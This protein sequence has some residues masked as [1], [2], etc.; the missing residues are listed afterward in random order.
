MQH[1]MSSSLADTSDVQDVLAMTLGVAQTYALGVAAETGIADRLKDGPRSV[2]EIAKA[3]TLEQGALLRLMRVLTRLGLLEEL[4]PGTFVNTGK[5]RLLQTGAPRSVRH[6]AMLMAQECFA[7]SWPHL[8]H[9]V[10]TGES[11]F[12]KVSGHR[13]Y[14]YFRR[15][16]AVGSVMNQAM[17][18]LS[19]QEGIVIRDAYEFSS[20]LLIVDVGG[21]RGGLLLSILEAHASI[22][23]I[24]LELPHVAVEA[25][26]VLATQDRLRVVVGDCLREVPAGGDLYILKRVLPDHTDDMALTAL[27]NV[28]SAIAPQGR[29]IIADPDA[30][31]L[32]GRGFDMLMLMVFGGKLRSEPEFAVL[33]EKS[34]FRLNRTINTA[35]SIK[36]VEAVPV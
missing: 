27:R 11:T 18:E 9:S 4:T 30:E 15:N 26:K 10:R 24:L 31:T 8:L 14:E 7:G 33:L 12:E 23:G 16:P 35:S 29:L 17:D 3:T 20:D 25:E 19:S 22:R 36:L 6:Y 5:G 32:Y 34:G 2:A 28:R 1:D 21:G 13:I